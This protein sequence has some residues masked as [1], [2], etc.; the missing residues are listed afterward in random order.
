MNGHFPGIASE[1]FS[2]PLLENN[3]LG[4]AN[5]AHRVIV[6]GF[7]RLVDPNRN[8]PFGALR[9]HNTP[10]HGHQHVVDV[11]NLLSYTLPGVQSS[12]ERVEVN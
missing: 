12:E 6:H 5:L 3:I 11:V 8:V 7:L 2:C 1:Q 4:R 9:R 10:R